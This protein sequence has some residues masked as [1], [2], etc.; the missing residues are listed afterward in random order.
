M[1]VLN[2]SPSFYMYRHIRPDTNE[3]FYV[4]IGRHQKKWKHARINCLNN[5]N[6]HWI[7]IVNLNS[8]NFKSEIVFDNM[9]QEEAC[10]K[11]CE[12][13]KLYGRSDLK[14]G[15]L[16]NLTDGGEGGFNLSE[17]T[18]RKISLKNKNNGSAHFLRNL[19]EDI[20]KKRSDSLKGKNNG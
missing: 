4:G 16:C 14:Q 8:G 15:T 12:F 9:T 5:R 17:E 6:Q 2:A 10:Q 18:K 13:I 3:V 20:K 19:P 11:E 7:N 1:E